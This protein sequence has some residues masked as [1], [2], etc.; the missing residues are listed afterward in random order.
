[1]QNHKS[2]CCYSTILIHF[3]FNPL[4][5]FDRSACYDLTWLMLTSWFSIAR[6]VYISYKLAQ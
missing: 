2:V 1:M 3:A 6:N 4:P 5:A